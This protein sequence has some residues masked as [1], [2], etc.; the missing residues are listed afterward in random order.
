[1][2]FHSIMNVH[3]LRK[4]MEHF[5]ANTIETVLN[6]D[7]HV[8]EKLHGENFRIG[9][10]NNKWI[11]GQRNNQWHDFRNHVKFSQMNDNLKNDIETIKNYIIE[12]G[13]T[14]MFFFGELVGNGLQSGFNWPFNGLEVRWFAIKINGLYM[15]IKMAFEIFNKLEIKTAPVV[16][17][18][19]KIRDALKI[20]V[21]EM[22]S[23]ETGDDHV[24]GV[25]IVPIEIPDGLW[26]YADDLII[27]HKSTRFSEIS[28]PKKRKNSSNSEEKFESEFNKFVTV[29]RIEHAIEKLSEKGVNITHQMSDMAHIPKE[30]LADI[31]KE[32]NN[33]EDL[34]KQDRKS[35]ISE[36]AS[37]YNDMLMELVEKQF[38]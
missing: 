7:A 17:E 25:V 14:D 11:Y 35:V 27:K 26:R 19:M 28:K 32:E 33:D 9:I 31:S 34:P 6:L 36:I 10:K 15:N 3:N 13:F 38:S 20:N 22:H 5:P 30:V 1:M 12:N 23:I 18:S 21:D 29:A 2:K 37:V 8:T 24:E 16:S 4:K